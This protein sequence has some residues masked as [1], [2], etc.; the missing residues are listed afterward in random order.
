MWFKQLTIGITI[1]VIG[2]SAAEMV[3]NIT[4]PTAFSMRGV[5]V[6]TEGIPSWPIVVGDDV[7]TGASAAEIRFL[8]GSRVMIAEKSRAEIINKDGRLTL[9]LVSGTMRFDLARGSHLSLLNKNTPV[10]GVTGTATTV[11]G[12]TS[13][14]LSRLP[15]PPPPGPTSDR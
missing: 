12:V 8:D 5:P 9:R 7:A 14:V 13:P 2:V 4:S 3:G 11:A 6:K 10:A 1:L 15:A